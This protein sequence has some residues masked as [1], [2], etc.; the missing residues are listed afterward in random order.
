MK[1]ASRKSQVASEGAFG[2]VIGYWLL[3]I[4]SVAMQRQ[5]KPKSFTIHHSPFT[6]RKQSFRFGSSLLT[7]HSSLDFHRKEFR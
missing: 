2:A 4:G 1:V 5:P 6:I 7:P 3:V